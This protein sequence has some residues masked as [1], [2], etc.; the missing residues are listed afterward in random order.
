[1]LIEDIFL[2]SNS[3]SSVLSKYDIFIQWKFIAVKKKLQFH[4]CVTKYQPLF[5]FYLSF[6]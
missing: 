4:V 3:T 2:R 1:M 5:I 6:F